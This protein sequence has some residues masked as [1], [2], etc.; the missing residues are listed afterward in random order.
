MKPS[1]DTDLVRRLVATQ[2]PRWADL[3][4]KQ[5]V[6]GGSDH[7]I[8]RL[9]TGLQVRL[10]RG[11]WSAGQAEKDGRWLP[12]IADRLP[13]PGPHGDLAPQKPSSAAARPKRS[14]AVWSV[15]SGRTPGIH[16]QTVAGPV[17]VSI[18]V[19]PLSAATGSGV[20]KGSPA[21]RSRRRIRCSAPTCA[22]DRVWLTRSTN[23]RSP[24]WSM[25]VWLLVPCSA[26]TIVVP[27]GKPHAASSSRSGG[28]IT[29][30]FWRHAQG[31]AQPVNGPLRAGAGDGGSESGEPACGG[32]SAGN[33]G[34][35]G[36]AAVERLSGEQGCHGWRCFPIL[37]DQAASSQAV[38]AD[39]SCQAARS[40]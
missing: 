38:A 3:P 5:V 23:R 1:I 7:A 39:L 18:T 40:S 22:A 16:R 26:P 33:A 27:G 8:F 24:W 37:R 19:S 34:D 9:G 4:L 15:R 25:N 6:P 31:R 28:A 20:W 21:C 30:Q 11:D 13:L 10:P 17:A 32:H 12:R 14:S 35:H 29:R 36:H 2:F